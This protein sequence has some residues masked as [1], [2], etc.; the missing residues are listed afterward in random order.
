MHADPCRSCLNADPD[1]I[2]LEWGPKLHF[3]QVPR[4]HPIPLAC[5]PQF[6][7]FESRACRPYSGTPL[8]VGKL[9]T[10]CPKLLESCL[11]TVFCLGPW[12][13]GFYEM[14]Q[15]LTKQIKQITT[16]SFQSERKKVSSDPKDLCSIGIFHTTSWYEV[17]I[18]LTAK[19]SI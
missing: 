10:V 11:N 14:E 19:D 7:K 6:E 9:S 13:F 8:R 18:R 15:R 17:S 16:I 3:S 1:S 2:G 4:I 12:H 5:G